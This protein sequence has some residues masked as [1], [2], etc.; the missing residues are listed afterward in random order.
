[1]ENLKSIVF[2]GE[3]QEY[4]STVHR[5]FMI[6]NELNKLGY[7][8]KVLARNIPLEKIPNMFQQVKDWRTIIKEKPNIVILHRSSNFI[9]YYMIKRVKKHTKV[10]YDF[11]D[12]LFHGQL[13]GRMAANSHIKSV[14]RQSDAVTAGSH[15]LEEYAR[16]VNKNVYLLST[17]VDTKLFHPDVRKNAS[18]DDKITI[19]WLGAGTK[20]QLHYLR[21]LKEP[22]RN[23]NRK[24]DIKFKIVSALSKE[25]IMEFKNEAFDVDFGLDYW[26]PLNKMPS[27]IADFD[28]GVMPLSDDPYSRGKCAMKALEYMAMG[29]PV[30]A[31]DV[32]E[33]RYVIDNEVNGFLASNTEEWVNNLNLLIENKNIREK[34][35]KKGLETV[36]KKY[37]LKVCGAMLADILTKMTDR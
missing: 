25:V 34:I 16:N 21:L 14:I 12:A 5:C 19:G 37:S 31:S 15:Y 20:D 6:S 1:M 9:D 24:Y 4:A 35:G 13:L 33:N 36:E 10:I 26:A 11:D 32:G 18:C 22:L 23:L 28:I 7:F 27:L 30:V 3:G 2:I 8:S 17:P 29:I